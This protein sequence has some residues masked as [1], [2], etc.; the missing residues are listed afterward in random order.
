MSSASS[1]PTSPNSFSMIAIFLPWLAVK[2][3]LSRVV[4][5]EP[6]KPVSTVTGTRVSGS[7]AIVRCVL[8]RGV[9]SGRRSLCDWRRQARRAATPP[10]ANRGGAGGLR[11]APPH[12]APRCVG[13]L[14]RSCM[15]AERRTD[16]MADLGRSAASAPLEPGDDERAD[17]RLGFS[18]PAT[19]EDEEQDR[20]RGK[21]KRKKEH[22]EKRKKEHKEHKAHKAHKEHKEHKHK[23]KHS[24]ERDHRSA[25][26]DGDHASSSAPFFNAGTQNGSDGSSGVVLWRREHTPSMAVVATRTVRLGSA[27]HDRAIEPPASTLRWTAYGVTVI[28]GRDPYGAPTLTAGGMPATGTWIITGG[29]VPDTTG[30]AGMTTAGTMMYTAVRRRA[31]RS[32]GRRHAPRLRLEA[33]IVSLRTGGATATIHTEAAHA[34]GRHRGRH[35]PHIGRLTAAA[36]RTR[37]STTA[38]GS[39]AATDDTRAATDDMRAATEDT[40]AATDDM[41]ANGGRCTTMLARR[42]PVVTTMIVAGTAAA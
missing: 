37:E 16:P 19:L 18:P 15:S 28:R 10:S 9:C 33:P 40:R 24:S 20:H 11:A 7:A 1:T 27:H 8:G 6:R 22:K 13:L 2:M 29:M 26:D 35:H 42:L 14:S 12:R 3:W 41:R 17:A 39:R 31:T 36:T 38:E 25:A 30:T 34:G 23:R 32:G 5:P 21:E 4:L